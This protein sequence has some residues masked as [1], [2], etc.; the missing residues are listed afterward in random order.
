[1]IGAVLLMAYAHVIGGVA[2]QEIRFHGLNPGVRLVVYDTEW[3]GLPESFGI[4]LLRA[5]TIP[6]KQIHR[7]ADLRGSVSIRDAKDALDFVRLRTSPGTW[8]LGWDGGIEVEILSSSSSQRSRNYGIATDRIPAKSEGW[9]G[10]VSDRLFREVHVPSA[11]VKA[12]GADFVVT[13]SI[14]E[15]VQGYDEFKLRVVEEQVGPDGAYK[16]KVIRSASAPRNPDIFWFVPM[17]E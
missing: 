4:K 8:D 2:N 9:F 6:P 13:R 12:N 5:P 7:L 1:M 11:A 17:K 16:R 10:V 14:L 15:K 3:G